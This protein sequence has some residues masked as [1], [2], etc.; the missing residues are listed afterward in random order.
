MMMSKLRK[1]CLVLAMICMVSTSTDLCA[2]RA[3]PVTVTPRTIRPE[4]YDQQ[5]QEC[6]QAYHAA[7]YVPSLRPY[8]VV[9][10]IV[11]AAVVVVC[12]SSRQ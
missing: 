10:L 4:L 6:G 8:V 3:R 11:V 9:G 1:M 7:T 12:F 2:S 5:C